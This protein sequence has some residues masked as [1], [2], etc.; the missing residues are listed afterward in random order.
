MVEAT[1]RFTEID[2]PNF[3]ISG[4]RKFLNTFKQVYGDNR[5]EDQWDGFLM[6]SRDLQSFYDGHWNPLTRKEKEFLNKF[7]NINNDFYV[8]AVSPESC[9][10]TIRHELAHAFWETKPLYRRKVKAVLKKVN[11]NPIFKILRETGYPEKLLLD[12]AQAVLSSNLLWLKK[13][14]LKDYHKYYKVSGQL[15]MIFEELA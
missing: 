8:I 4:R 3:E 1:L 11:L 15:N 7:K 14:G 13:M 9:P 5:A 2:N 12:E 6:P 10:T